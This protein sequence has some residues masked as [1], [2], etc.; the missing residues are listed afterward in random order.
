MGEYLSSINLL[1]K[2]V[3]EWLSKS[4]SKT[5]ECGDKKAATDHP[6]YTYTPAK[7]GNKKDGNNG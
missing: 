7:K 1:K 2:H 3:D 6:E 5:C 4:L